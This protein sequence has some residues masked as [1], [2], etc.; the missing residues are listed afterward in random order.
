MD[1][2]QW[3]FGRASD[4][5]GVILVKLID[6]SGKLPSGPVGK[7]PKFAACIIHITILIIQMSSDP[8]S[9]VYSSCFIA[10]HCSQLKYMYTD[11]RMLKH[12]IC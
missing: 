1:K 4:K 2:C 12:Q 5:F 9:Y 8:I 3:D 6:Y 7:N 10:L 11:G